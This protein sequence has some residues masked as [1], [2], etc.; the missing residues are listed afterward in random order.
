[1]LPSMTRFRYRPLRRDDLGMLTRWMSMPHVARWWG[2]VPTREEVDDEFGAYADG[3]EPVHAFVAEEDG[4]PFAYL[5]WAR[6][7]SYPDFAKLM[8]VGD[9]DAAN[10]DVLI[11]EPDYAYRGLGAPLI[12][13]FLRE[14][15]FAEPSVTSCIIDPDV[16]NTSAIRAYEKA[17]FRFVRVVEDDGE[18]NQNHLMELTREGLARLP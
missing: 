2:G 7:A 8:G 6:L 9:L 14:V 1:M 18:G 15:V 16:R 4:R 5:Q 3:T 17:G 11:G 10:C 13:G 12:V